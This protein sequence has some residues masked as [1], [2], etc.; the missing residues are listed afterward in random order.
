VS[1]SIIDRP[2][3]VEREFDVDRD[4]DAELVLRRRLATDRMVA[5]A[6][7][8]LSSLLATAAALDLDDAPGW[9]RLRATAHATTSVLCGA[10]VLPESLRVRHHD[11]D[12]VVARTIANAWRRVGIA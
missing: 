11:T 1:T 4:L 3:I 7:D 5:A 8:R 10:G 2:R 9:A 6:C 12:V